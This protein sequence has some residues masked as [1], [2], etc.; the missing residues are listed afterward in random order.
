VIVFSGEPEEQ[1]GTFFGRGAAK[2]A[3]TFQ[4]LTNDYSRVESALDAVLAQGPGGLTHIAAGIDQ[5]TIELMGIRGALSRK[6]PS[7]EKI[8]LFLTDGTPTLPYGPQFEAENV[9]AVLRAAGRSQYSDIRIHS[10][11]IGPEA[12]DAPVATVEMARRTG[13][14]F[15]PVRHPGMLADA[16]ETV[17]FAN[18]K[19][20]VVRNT[21]NGK[22][23]EPFR[24]TADGAWSGF[25]PLEKGANQLQVNA[26]ADDATSAQRVVSVRLDPNAPEAAI[27]QDLVVHRNRLLEECLRNLK[28]VRV[29]AEQDAAENMRKELAVEIEK[30]RAKANQRAAEQSKR[31]ELGVEDEEAAP[32][33]P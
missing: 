25:L 18:I 21:T 23:A 14:Y 22:L 6:D 33:A 28:Q 19:E 3:A 10:F 24:L 29:A 2:P 9:R 11:A 15:T 4:A 12:L 27:P 17:D 8:V 7:S 16:I 30:E 32:N 20:V 1:G 31:L 13:G 5:A 26:R